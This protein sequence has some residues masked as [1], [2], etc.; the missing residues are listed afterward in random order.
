MRSPMGDIADNREV[1]DSTWDW[2]AQGEEWSAWWGGT[3]ALWFGALLPR[4]HAF[5]PA[6]TV[7]EIAPGY[8]RWTEHLRAHCDRL[9]IVDLAER[10][11]D[12]CRR[13]FAGA[14]NIEYHVNDGR[15]L[16]MVADGTVD[17][18]F[19]FDSLVHAE[20]D[21]LDAYLAELAA[22][23][24]PEGVAFLHHSNVG[25]LRG[26]H[27]LAM[28]T[29]ARLRDRLVRRGAL[30]DVYAWRAPS[31]SAAHVAQTCEALGLTCFSQE[32]VN[33]ERGPYLTDCISLIARQG[34]RRDHERRLVRNPLFRREARR[35]ASL[36]AGS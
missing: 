36:Y 22:K 28:R 21:V 3:P 30:L 11:I 17:L 8:G 19:S 1:W 24:A 29:P 12:H 35:M 7:L 23:L 15:S 34:S 20:A 33:W 6:G 10:C 31:V 5:I 26:L 18:A 27:A 14:D 4:I 32:L 13:R 16:P 9:V 2:S 25:A